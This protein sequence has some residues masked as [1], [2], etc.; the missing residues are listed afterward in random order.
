MFYKTERVEH[1]TCR[2]LAYRGTDGIFHISHELFARG[3]I[4]NR[5]TPDYIKE[6]GGGVPTQTFLCSKLLQVPSV[7]FI[8]Q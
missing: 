3:Q 6:L 5:L 1:R 2:K 7:Y 8:Q 4:D